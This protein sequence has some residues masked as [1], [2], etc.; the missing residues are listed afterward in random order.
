MNS[1]LKNI[2]FSLA[3]IFFVLFQ[4]S[5][6]SAF[7][8]LRISVNVVLFFLLSLTIFTDIITGLKWALLAGIIMDL[9]SAYGGAVITLSYIGT[10]MLTYLLF[11]RYISNHF[12]SI[13][14]LL[15]SGT[16][17]YWVFF[18]TFSWLSLFLGMHSFPLVLA[19]L[20]F[21]RIFWRTT[22]FLLS[23]SSR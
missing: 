21:S 20:P 13:L 11:R 23:N 1:T 9:H 7:E 12:Y 16:I 4:V 19:T 6:L 15:T 17:I 10:L 22:F 3:V 5:F 2:F 14:L 8:S 18:Y